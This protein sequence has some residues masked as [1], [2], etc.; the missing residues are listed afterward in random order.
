M[1]KRCRSGSGI[2]VCSLVSQYLVLCLGLGLGSLL[3]G[4]HGGLSGAGVDQLAIAQYKA[5][6]CT[7]GSDVFLAGT[8]GCEVELLSQSGV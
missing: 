5:E 1:L 3:D 4:G 2:G 8:G 6:I 7:S